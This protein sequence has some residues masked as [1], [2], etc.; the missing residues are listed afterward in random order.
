[1]WE[2]GIGRAMSPPP[3]PGFLGVPQ[4]CP[5]LSR[6]MRHDE[7]SNMMPE[8][9]RLSINLKRDATGIREVDQSPDQSLAAR[10]KRLDSVPPTAE[11]LLDK[12][13]FDVRE[14]DAAKSALRDARES[15]PKNPFPRARI[16]KW[17][18][19]GSERQPN[20]V[21]TYGVSD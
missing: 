9:K 20:P 18:L 19:A 6:P 15:V 10:R 13:V 21:K 3:I 1:M 14:L 11:P 8:T 4:C 17:R 16:R 5:L 2:P 7:L 12:R